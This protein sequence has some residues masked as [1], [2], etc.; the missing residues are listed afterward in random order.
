M[1]TFRLLLR[2]ICFSAG[3]ALARNQPRWE[4]LHLDGAVAFTR[5]YYRES[6]KDLLASQQEA[7]SA[8]AKLEELASIWGELGATWQAIGRYADAET[9]D[10]QTLEVRERV[11]G[12]DSCE[13]ATI[14]NN[15]AALLL[16]EGKPKQAGPLAL[17]VAA[18]LEKTSHD[19]FASR[20]CPA[21]PV[22]GASTEII[23]FGSSPLESASPLCEKQRR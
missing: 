18:I 13:A 19:R 22:Q 1:K 6:D 5:G 21:V 9:L 7:E 11:F 2:I 23:H 14:M 12:P 20:P 10:C 17:R 4:Q 3:L 16:Q 15:R 8:G